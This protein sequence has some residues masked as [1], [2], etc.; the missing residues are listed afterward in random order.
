MA[1]IV[2]LPTRE[3][4]APCE[5]IDMAAA[6]KALR[7][8][9]RVEHAVNDAVR[10]LIAELG[11]G[12]ASEVGGPAAFAQLVSERLANHPDFVSPVAV[13]VKS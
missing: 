11:M 7:Q 9:A 1:R 5:V 10:A 12:W 2:A 3:P 6:K 4:P 13:E 8:R